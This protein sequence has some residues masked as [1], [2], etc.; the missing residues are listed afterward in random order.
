MP[1]VTQPSISATSFQP[2][3]G[4]SCREPQAARV[5][6]R[7]VAP[8]EKARDPLLSETLRHRL[9]PPSP[10]P[11]IPKVSTLSP[12]QSYSPTPY[13]QKIALDRILELEAV[14]MF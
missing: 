3:L 1:G 13:S 6:V 2:S 5:G 14:V 4:L 12:R 9:R 10:P 11:R 7:E 8:P